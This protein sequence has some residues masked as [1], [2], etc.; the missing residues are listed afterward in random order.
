MPDQ[1][2]RLRDANGL[3]SLPAQKWHCFG[4]IGINLRLRILSRDFGYAKSTTTKSQRISR[5]LSSDLHVSL[6]QGSHRLK[7]V[8]VML[9]QRALDLC[10]DR[11]HHRPAKFIEE[12]EDSIPSVVDLPIERIGNTQI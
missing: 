1:N 7:G 5:I 2:R 10:Q 8:T 6:E 3:Q 11:D 4:S 9:R 12:K